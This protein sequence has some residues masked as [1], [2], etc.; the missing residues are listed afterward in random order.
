MN[1]N[2]RLDFVG[3]TG[4]TGN[5]IYNSLKEKYS[6]TNLVNSKNYKDY[7]RKDFNDTILIDFSSKEFVFEFIEANNGKEF[8]NLFYIS[9]VT[10]FLV[11]EFEYI[12]NSFVNMK[13]FG[14]HFPNFSIGINLIND[15][16]RKV[17]SYFFEAE[18]IEMHHKTKK[19]K[20][21]GTSLMTS[22]IINQVWKQNNIN[23]QVNVHSIRLP[24]LVAHQTILFSNEFGEIIEIT[25]HSISRSCFSIG[26]HKVLEKIFKSKYDEFVPGF[27]FNLNLL[28]FIEG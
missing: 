27:K 8:R 28:E 13:A 3:Y 12:N 11:E 14:L 2:F 19:D 4:K 22:T 24:S 6:F 23:N 9:G 25:H 1:H 5:I 20:P 10:G 15:F 17:S 16:V 18:I 7:L 26:V 21:S